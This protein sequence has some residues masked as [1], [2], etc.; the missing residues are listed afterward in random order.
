[1]DL[2]M[3]SKT[4]T[5]PPGNLAMNQKSLKNLMSAAEYQLI[6]LILAITVY[7]PV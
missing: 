4:G 2:R 5:F 1:M 6:N 7:L 3:G